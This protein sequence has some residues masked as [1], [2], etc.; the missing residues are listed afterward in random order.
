MQFM[1][2]KQGWFF[3]FFFCVQLW[4]L[5]GW[6]KAYVWMKMI[7]TRMSFT[8][9]ANTSFCQTLYVS[10]MKNGEGKTKQ[11]LTNFFA[12]QEGWIR[13]RSIDS[14]LCDCQEYWYKSV[15]SVQPSSDLY[16][17]IGTMQSYSE[18]LLWVHRSPTAINFCAHSWL[19]LPK[20]FIENVC[21]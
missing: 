5:Y 19:K 9:C 12:I 6:M 11:L 10:V 4:R 2:L 7:N 8:F 21:I 3:F 14:R 18:W 16:N 15:E 20:I 1:F 17:E 13:S